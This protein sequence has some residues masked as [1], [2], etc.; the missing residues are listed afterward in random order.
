MF[1]SAFRC[2]IYLRNQLPDLFPEVV[3]NAMPTILP[4][5]AEEYVP[6]VLSTI[7]GASLCCWTLQCTPQ[8]RRPQ[9]P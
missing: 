2:R 4:E 6:V 3:D 8:V 5:V 7:R 1:S 9:M